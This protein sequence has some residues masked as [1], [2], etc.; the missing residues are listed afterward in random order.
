MFCLLFLC[1]VLPLG[2]T[3]PHEARHC[4]L[5]SREEPG[6]IAST[7]C[8]WGKDG[9]LVLGPGRDREAHD[10]ASH[11]ESNMSCH[12]C[13]I[14]TPDSAAVHQAPTSSSLGLLPQHQPPL[15]ASEGRRCSRHHAGTQPDPASPQDGA[16]RAS[17]GKGA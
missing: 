12:L 7:R 16:G 6:A 13:F 8:Y 2:W 5:F 14:P 10:K 4:Y 1:L 11:L 17:C 9:C 3:L 15:D